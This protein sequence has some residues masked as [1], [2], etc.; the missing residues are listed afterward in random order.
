MDREQRIVSQKP[1]VEKL[2]RN[3][4]HAAENPETD[5][6]RKCLRVGSKRGE[7]Q[8]SGTRTLR[9]T[10]RATLLGWPCSGGPASRRHSIKLSYWWGILTNKLI[11]EGKFEEKESCKL[12]LGGSCIRSWGTGDKSCF[13]LGFLGMGYTG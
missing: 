4:V 9:L 10:A 2:C 13:K 8:K 7:S 1:E 6:W 12:A 5:A 3:R 11:W